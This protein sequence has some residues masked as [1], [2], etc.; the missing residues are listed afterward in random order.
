MSPR[1]HSPLSSMDQSPISD[2]VAS[3]PGKSRRRSTTPENRRGHPMQHS[4]TYEERR[5]K[6]QGAGAPQQ[7]QYV[8]VAFWLLRIFECFVSFLVN[9][10]HLGECGG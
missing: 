5:K 9:A 4:A 8:F 1:S 7:S 6:A 10:L 2:S 3:A